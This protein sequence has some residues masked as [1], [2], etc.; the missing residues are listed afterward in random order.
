M[1]AW[2]FLKVNDQG[3]EFVNEITNELH[4]LTDVEQCIASVYYPQA[5]GLVE[6]QKSF[7]KAS[8]QNAT[9]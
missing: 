3:R 2:L 9:Q 4:H 7:I 1:K 8:D 6:R 5:N